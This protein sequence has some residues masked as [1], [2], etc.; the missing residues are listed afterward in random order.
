MT[1]EATGLTVITTAD[2]A[3][4]DRR[5]M[6]R[7]YTVLTAANCGTLTMVVKQK[8]VGKTY[9]NT[10]LTVDG[11]LQKGNIYCNNASVVE[12]SLNATGNIS[13]T[14]VVCSVK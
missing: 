1:G 12:M 3:K 7:M 5:A 13:S 2:S 9:K 4:T 11:I 14:W 10:L 8:Y 6:L